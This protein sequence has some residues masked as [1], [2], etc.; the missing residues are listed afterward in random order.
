VN[1]VCHVGHCHPDVVRAAT[2][3]VERLKTRG[4]LLATDG[5]QHNVLKIKPPMVLSEDDA[6]AVIEALD[7]VLREI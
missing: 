7:V 6:T 4:I 5:P 1:N 3:I 2:E